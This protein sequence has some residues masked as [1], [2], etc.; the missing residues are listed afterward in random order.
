MISDADQR[1]NENDSDEIL[2]QVKR[3]PENRVGKAVLSG[4][5]SSPSKSVLSPSVP[6]LQRVLALAG[7]EKRR[8]VQRWLEPSIGVDSV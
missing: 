8:R 6:R 1:I 5:V 2:T 3:L 7:S 4:S